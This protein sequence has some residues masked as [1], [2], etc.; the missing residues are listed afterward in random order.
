DRPWRSK[1]PEP[2]FGGV[3]VG[4]TSDPLEPPPHDDRATR[5]DLRAFVADGRITAMPRAGSRRLL[6]ERVAPF[7]EPGRRSEET[8]V[9]RIL[10]RLH[11]DHAALRRYLVDANLLAH[12]NVVYWRIGAPV[13]GEDD[14]RTRPSPLRTVE[15][16]RGARRPR[17][18]GRTKGV[19]A[20][21]VARRPGRQAPHHQRR[22]V[23]VSGQ[24][25]RH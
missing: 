22:V 25:P 2:P 15:W 5:K 3:L 24:H 20:C 4:V 19:I 11:D 18:V 16:N 13:V 17:G 6:L 1:G 21:A 12:E 10:L 14:D 23:Q 7:F 8:E 9:D